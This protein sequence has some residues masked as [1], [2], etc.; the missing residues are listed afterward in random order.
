V[1]LLVAGVVIVLA[2]ISSVVVKNDGDAPIRL[3]GCSI[4]DSLDLAPGQ[5]GSVDVPGPEGCTVYDQ[6]STRYIGCVTL[7]NPHSSVVL[8]RQSLHPA[9]TARECEDIG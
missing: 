9:L 4:D 3:S 8:V 1:A 2:S 6:A 7:A 5:S